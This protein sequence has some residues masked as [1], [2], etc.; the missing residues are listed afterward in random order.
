MVMSTTRIGVLGGIVLLFIASY[1]FYTRK[2][3]ALNELPIPDGVVDFR[4][5]LAA[6]PST[7]KDVSI[8]QKDAPVTMVEYASM[9]CFHCAEFHNKTF[10]YLEDKYIKTGKLRYILREFPLDSVSTV[11]VMLARCAEKRMDGG[12]WGFVSLLFNKQDDW[13][14]SKNYRDALL[15]MAKFAGF[16]KNDFDTCL[17]DQNILDDIKAGKKR[18]SED[19]AIDSTPVFFIGGNLYLGDMSEG[20]FSKIIDSMIQDSTRR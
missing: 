12:Y 18:A 1:F 3:S 17:N 2:G 6:S 10:K 11:A 20:V 9:T 13:I 14:N 19:F 15:N 7:M 8:G 4:A 5:L 16:S